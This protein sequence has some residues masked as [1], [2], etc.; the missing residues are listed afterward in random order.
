MMQVA[1]TSYM[2]ACVGRVPDELDRLQLRE[3]TVVIL[4]GDHGWFLGEHGMWCKHANYENAA[5]TPLIISV[6]R[7][8][9][10]PSLPWA[11]S[12]PAPPGKLALF[13]R[14][15]LRLQFAISLFEQ[16]TCPSS[17]S[18]RN[19]LCFARIVRSGQCQ[20]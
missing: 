15:C 13:C 3:K 20:A 17:L 4:W 12:H 9:P 7:P 14:G 18:W 2:D 11:P 16:S 8:R 19:W 5:H 10:R 1:A 6:P